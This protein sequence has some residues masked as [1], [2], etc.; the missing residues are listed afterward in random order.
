MATQWLTDRITID[1]ERCSG[2][3]TIRGTR[4]RVLDI[5]EMLA[6]GMTEM[7]IL[8]EFPKLEPAD[9]RAALKFAAEG[10]DHPILKAGWA[11]MFFLLDAQLPSSLCESF[12]KRGHQ[13]SHVDDLLP[14][15]ARDKDILALSVRI[16]AI[17]VTKDS[18]FS[19][20]RLHQP[21]ARIIWLRFGNVN[22]V[23][24]RE[25]LDAV[26]S[27]LEVQIENGDRLIEIR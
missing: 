16:Q 14:D 26:W 15:D 9:I 21:Q 3:P 6:D 19:R 17:I 10:L 5:L 25:K 23:V 12:R 18:D 11:R 24:L 1:P 7:D 27:E 4:M 13:A 20:L 22:N 8:T 2:R